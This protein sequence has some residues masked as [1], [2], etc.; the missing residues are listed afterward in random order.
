M[1][2]WQCPWSSPTAA[3]QPSVHSS[4]TQRWDLHSCVGCITLKMWQLCLFAVLTEGTLLNL[5]LNVTLKTRTRKL[6]Q[7]TPW[8]PSAPA[9]AVGGACNRYAD[10]SNKKLMS[11]T[12]AAQSDFCRQSLFRK[13]KGATTHSKENIWEIKEHCLIHSSRTGNLEIRVVYF[14]TVRAEFRVYM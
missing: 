4:Q 8:S 10:R 13:P 11:C 14:T 5:L 1:R 9:G 7:S 2:P 6:M 3:Q 12:K